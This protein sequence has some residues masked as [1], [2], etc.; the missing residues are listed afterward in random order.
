MQS[1]RDFANSK[2]SGPH[3]CALGGTVAQT[4]GPGVEVNQIVHVILPNTP[5]CIPL[6]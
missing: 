1:T 3:L 2:L 4:P 6:I 5:N